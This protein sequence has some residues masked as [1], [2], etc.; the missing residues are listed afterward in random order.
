PRAPAASP[1]VPTCRSRNGRPSRDTRPA[2]ARR[3]APRP[4]CSA[5]PRPRARSSGASCA[6]DEEPLHAAAIDA[7]EVADVDLDL[8]GADGEGAGA[9]AEAVRPTLLHDPPSVPPRRVRVLPG[10]G[11]VGRARADAEV[12]VRKLQM[13]RVDEPPHR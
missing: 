8:L 3:S 4:R 13:A 10:V 5:P 2:R 9:Q 12:P 11:G 1:P 7:N 6:P